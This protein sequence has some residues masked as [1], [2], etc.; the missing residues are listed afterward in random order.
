MKFTIAKSGFVAGL[1]RIQ[2][3]VQTRSTMPILSN[4][5]I[6]AK[7]K[8]IQLFATDLELGIQDSI[9]AEIAVEGAMTVSA[10]KLFEISKELKEETIRLE[11]EED[12]GIVI[13][14]GKS[15]FKL[16]GLSAEE[17]PYFPEIK[18][19]ARLT[20]PAAFLQEMIRKSA[21][22][23]SND[24]TRVA[25][26]GVLLHM[27]GSKSNLIVMVGTDGHR[28]SLVSRDIPGKKGDEKEIKVIIPRKTLQE[29][30][31]YL[32]EGSR[33]SIELVLS[34]NHV[35]FR[36]GEYTLL[37]RL[38]DGKFPS[39]D[40]V[41]PKENPSRLSLNRDAFQGAV[42]RVSIL[43]DEK[44]HAVKLNL[45]KDELL[46]SSSNPEMG[47]A[48]E[49]LAVGYSD[50]ALE[51]AFNVRYIQDVAS[52]LQGEEMH[53]LFFDPLSPVR[54]EDPGD[55]GFIGV[56]MPMRL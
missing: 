25:L 41:I 52:A 29:L 39:Y 54:I 14:S 13:R 44:T 21:F 56:I 11:S 3:V 28:L 16:R 32:D 30:K 35:L 43:S 5:R 46:I 22:S 8:K 10:R 38:I 18:E 33:E 45:K 26:N 40:E 49:T 47:E 24:L 51:L 50:E 9:P 55:P 20:L 48:S 36:D 4:V 12:L 7:D 2:S 19:R 17:F 42:R 31:K 37:S 34:Q 6:Q 27:P 1:Q 53:L 23:V 15:K